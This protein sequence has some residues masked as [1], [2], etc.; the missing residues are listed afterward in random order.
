MKYFSIQY[1]FKVS[2]RYE[3]NIPQIIHGPCFCSVYRYHHDHE[4]TMT[5][6]V[7]RYVWDKAGLEIV[8]F[9]SLQNIAIYQ[10]VQVI[11]HKEMLL[12]L[13]EFYLS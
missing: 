3:N 12:I 2:L 6:T 1:T 9:I 13:P 8:C 4:L 11:I 5:V 7:T 10:V